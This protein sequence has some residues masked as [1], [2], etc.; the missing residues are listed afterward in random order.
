MLCTVY[1]HVKY[2]KYMY[3]ALTKSCATIFALE[4]IKYLFR[5]I[6]IK[7]HIMSIDRLIIIN[8]LKRQSYALV[9]CVYSAWISG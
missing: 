7:H 1:T 6:V 2:I 4:T 5:S 8:K 3:V 9:L